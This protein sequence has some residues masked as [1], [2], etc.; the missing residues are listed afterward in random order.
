MRKFALKT[1]DGK[2]LTP[3]RST[4]E[5]PMVVPSSYGSMT[6]NPRSKAYEFYEAIASWPGFTKETRP[7]TIS[8]AVEYHKA[9]EYGGVAEVYA[10]IS[11]FAKEKA[12]WEIKTRI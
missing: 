8:Q 3:S 4:K 7:R 2:D 1:F 10:A 5:P 11:A 9:Y 6:F 12:S